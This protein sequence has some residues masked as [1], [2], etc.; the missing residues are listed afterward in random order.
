MA[1]GGDAAPRRY[2]L[3]TRTLFRQAAA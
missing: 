1:T 2:A 3:R